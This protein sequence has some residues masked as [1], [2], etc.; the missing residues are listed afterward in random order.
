M[1]RR[2]GPVLNRVHSGELN[3]KWD[4]I[5]ANV[6]VSNTGVTIAH[7]G[8]RHV[9]KSVKRLSDLPESLRRACEQKYGSK[10][11]SS[12]A[13]VKSVA[14]AVAAGVEASGLGGAVLI[15]TMRGGSDYWRPGK[16]LTD[17]ADSLPNLEVGYAREDALCP[18]RKLLSRFREEESM[19]FGEYAESY[20]AELKRTNGRG[21]RVAAFLAVNALAR[22]L[23][24]VFYCTDP[25]LPGY[26]AT[27]HDD[28]A[29]F[30]D[31]H[32][33]TDESGYLRERG[34]HRVV[35]VECVARFLS[36]L[37]AAATIHELDA[38][39]GAA[40]RREW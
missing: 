9:R 12:T 21:L 4:G 1:T 37:G 23:L 30:P 25:S 27:F 16:L 32:Y 24:P 31:R 3:A 29:A 14:A 20:A 10:W 19:S 7:L 36:S 40:Y 38:N 26:T 28:T 35:L 8:C 34:C 39:V 11:V 5:V 13:A 17:V 2:D 33:A 15:D 22:G 6:S 18:G